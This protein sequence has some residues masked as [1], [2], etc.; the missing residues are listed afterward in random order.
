[1]RSLVSG[2]TDAIVREAVDLR[3]KGE[4][5]YNQNLKV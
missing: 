2:H 3:K 5:K 4:F 1:M